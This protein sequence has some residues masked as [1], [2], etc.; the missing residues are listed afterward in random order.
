[1]HKLFPDWYREASLQQNPEELELRWNGVIALVS[2]LEFD[3][4]L[5]VVQL[6]FGLSIHS[7][8]E[9]HFRGVFREADPTFPARD[10]DRELVILAAGA[11]SLV[12]QEEGA[13]VA[14]AALGIICA[15]FGHD[16]KQRPISDIVN[17]AHGTIDRKS[18]GSFTPRGLSDPQIPTLGLSAMAKKTKETLDAGTANQQ[19]NAST[20]MELIQLIASHTKKQRSYMDNQLH[21]I[22][23]LF[24]RQGE[25]IN[26]LWWLIAKATA[27]DAK[28]IETYSSPAD[29]CLILAKD[30]ADLTSNPFGLYRPARFLAKML[31]LL[32]VTEN[33]KVKAFDSIS[34]TDLV[35]REG[36]VAEVGD[37]IPSML[38]PLHLGLA[39]SVELKSRSSWGAAYERSTGVKP[40]LSKPALDF[41]LQ[42]YR[43]RLLLNSR[44]IE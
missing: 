40:S 20:M 9:G 32:Q 26:V 27:H 17:E 2:Q 29:V 12:L 42:F 22:Q 35:W 33:K 31:D 6:L 7:D 10:N 34:S 3:G 39:K 16:C 19:S 8:F 14:T 11:L 43:E 24:E 13:L 21:A 5:N 15:A 25:E 28:A 23:S 36:I 18:R 38:C 37:Y 1:M 41:A 30:L 44:P 4:C